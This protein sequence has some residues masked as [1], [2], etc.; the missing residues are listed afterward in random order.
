VGGGI[1]TGLAIGKDDVHVVP[2]EDVDIM[3]DTNVKG[4]VRVTREVVP[5]ML[6]RNKGHIINISRCWPIHAPSAVEA[7]A[8]H[9][10][11]RI[12]MVHLTLFPLPRAPSP[13]SLV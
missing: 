10:L 13:A 9:A 2:E 7:F 4:L 6:A 5:G 11:R 1:C 3:I 8:T 12:R